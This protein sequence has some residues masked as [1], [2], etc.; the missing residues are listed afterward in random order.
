MRLKY[1]LPA[2]FIVS[3][4][5]YAA[6]IN[7]RISLSGN[8]SYA[9]QGDIGY[10]SNV[11]V[12]NADQQSL[13]LMLDDSA[14]DALWSLHLDTTRQ[15]IKGL[16]ASTKHSSDLFR[17][18]DLSHNWVDDRDDNGSTQIGYELD[19]VYLK[20]EFGNFNLGL[21]RQPVDWGSGRFWQPLNVFGAFAPTDLDT[22]YK[23]GIDTGIVI[24][25]PSAF[26]SLEAVYAFA[27]H[28]NS[29][30]ENSSALYYR[31]QVG[32]NSEMA[33][34]TGT[35]IENSVYGASFESDWKG[36]GWRVEGVYYDLKEK[37]D[38]EW[39]WIA[40]LD[41]QFND[42]TLISTEWYDNGLGVSH[43]SSLSSNQIGVLDRYGLKQHFSQHILGIA[44]NRDIT[45]L[46]NANY[47][48][49]IS[50]MKD[51][52]G[53]HVYSALHQ[54]NFIYSVSDESEFLFSLQHGS[55]K[56]LDEQSNIRSEFGHLPDSLTL[57][58]RHYF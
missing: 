2:L 33:L 48:L 12:L 51:D 42:G 18:Y 4:C 14:G 55:G 30:I 9:R 20:H 44:V 45:P 19:H 27:P 32:S 1:L 15:H 47:S 24:W 7:G 37:N 21:G 31:R 28:D 26:S 57:I 25:Y 49:L 54:V 22:E 40:G 23:P 50:P 34:L 29:D 6:Q 11:D 39:F 53:H 58:Y 35:V 41:Y 13:R 17:Y 52:D 38:S 3:N 8:A 46:L 36:A 16:S 43:E 56:G 5:G 10:D